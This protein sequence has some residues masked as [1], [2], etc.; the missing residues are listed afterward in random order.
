VLIAAPSFSLLYSID[1]L[2]CPK[3]SVKVVGHQWY[4]S[5]ETTD[6]V[7]SKDINFDSYMLLEADLPKGALR[8][9]EVDN[10]IV[11]PVRT[12]TRVIITAADVLHS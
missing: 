10:R 7:N 6:M 4:W 3:I 9:L 1:A 11:L 5:Y 2:V 12:T 8:L